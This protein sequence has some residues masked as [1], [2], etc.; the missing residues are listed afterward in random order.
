MPTYRTIFDPVYEAYCEARRFRK[1]APE[2]IN[3]CDTYD[4]AQ[5]AVIDH[6]ME[7]SAEDLAAQVRL[8]RLEVLEERAPGLI[9]VLRDDPFIEGMMKKYDATIL[10]PKR[11]NQVVVIH[12]NITTIDDATIEKLRAWFEKDVVIHGWDGDHV[13]EYQPT[14]ALTDLPPPYD[15]GHQYL[16]IEAALILVTTS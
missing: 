16:S 5:E 1:P 14:L 7:C 10:I 3:L 6:Q 2:Y 15:Q 4:I 13:D 12:G 8:S 11:T 9:E